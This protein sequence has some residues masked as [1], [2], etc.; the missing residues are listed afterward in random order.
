MTAHDP[1][2]AHPDTAAIIAAALH[3]DLGETGDITCRALVPSAA[4]LT[5]T[6]TAKE[7]GVVCGMPLFAAVFAALGGGVTITECAADG[8]SV[9]VGEVVLRGHGNAAVLLQ[10]E[11]T[12][13]NLAQRLSGTATLTR[14][15]VDTVAGTRAGIFDTRKTTPG[16]RL[17]Q[18][19]AVRAGGG[20]NHRIGLYDQVLIKE[21]HIALMAA[22]NDGSSPASAVRRC[23]ET[24]GDAVIVECEIEDLADLAP[25]ISAGAD[26]VL[27]DNMGPALLRQ[28]VATRDRTTSPRPHVDLE[29]SGGITLQTLRAVAETGVERISV[30]ALTHS[31]LC[32]DLS[33]RCS[34]LSSAR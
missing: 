7:A 20:R 25:V 17:L 26:I 23:R 9:S 12:A 28:A 30:G 11:R 29:A 21:N 13:L 1:C 10:G 22:G 2:Y 8:R 18:K 33:M 4:Q 3:E 14:S 34:S 19:L 24:L 31:A 27:C 5:V 32:F 6:V 15:Y 16:L